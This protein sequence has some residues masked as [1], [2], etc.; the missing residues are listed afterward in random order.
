[1]TTKLDAEYRKEGFHWGLNPSS[2]VKNILHL[3]SQGT[4]L[5]IG[6]GEGR[7]ALFLA[8]N[9]FAV[10][11]IDIS[12]EGIKK[13]TQEAQK[14]GLH[15]HGIVA[16]ITTAELEKYDVILAINLLQ[17]L[18]KEKAYAT[19][20]KMKKHAEPDGIN[21]IQV[22]LKENQGSFPYLFSKDELK[23]LYSD[24]DILLYKEYET[25]KEKH[26]NGPWHCHYVAEIITKRKN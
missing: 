20:E 7:N 16:D 6:V 17:F 22:F 21:I 1:M 2:A 18:T 10:T 23:T 4:V 14:R 13:F 12:E 26:G 5:D 11:G 24:W 25:P 9:G 19:I 15:V 3:K 8:Q